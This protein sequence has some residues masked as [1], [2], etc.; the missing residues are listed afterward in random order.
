MDG[1]KRRTQPAACKS[2]CEVALAH[3]IGQLFTV[4]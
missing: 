4:S 1:L 3:S 2:I